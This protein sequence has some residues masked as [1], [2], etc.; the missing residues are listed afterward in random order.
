MNSSQIDPD[1][2]DPDE[3]DSDE[4]DSDLINVSLALCLS[5]IFAL[6]FAYAADALARQNALSVLCAYSGDVG[7]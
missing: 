1:E 2:T 7:R 6:F 4:T 3:T 5:L